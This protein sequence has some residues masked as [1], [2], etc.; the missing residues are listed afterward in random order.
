M[1]L[2]S[3]GAALQRLMTK[4][5]RGLTLPMCNVYVDDLLVFFRSKEEHLVH[6]TKLFE[7][8]KY[9]FQ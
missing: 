7:G 1:G 6:L 3:L 9:Y 5:T 2:K 8:L 4:V